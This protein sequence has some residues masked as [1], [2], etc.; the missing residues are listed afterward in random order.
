MHGE[1]LSF[2]FRI[3]EALVFLA[4]VLALLVFLHVVRGEFRCTDDFRRYREN[5]VEVVNVPN[6]S[7]PVQIPLLVAVSR[8]HCVALCGIDAV[9]DKHLACVPSASTSIPKD[10][11][12]VVVD[13]PSPPCSGR[14]SVVMLPDDNTRYKKENG[15]GRGV[16]YVNANGKLVMKHLD[17]AKIPNFCIGYFGDIGRFKLNICFPRM[18]T[19]DTTSSLVHYTI[20][21]VFVDMVLLPALLAVLPSWSSSRFALSGTH[22]QSVHR[23]EKGHIKSGPV[24]LENDFLAPVVEEMERIILADE[25]DSLAKFSG[26]F[27]LSHGHGL[28]AAVKTLSDF[29]VVFAPDFKMDMMLSSSSLFVDVSVEHSFDVESDLGSVSPATTL[30][31][32]EHCSS[33]IKHKSLLDTFFYDRNV[34]DRIHFPSYYRLDPFMHFSSLAGFDYHPRFSQKNKYGSGVLAMKAYPTFKHRF[35]HRNTYGSRHTKSNSAFDLWNADTKSDTF[36]S[37]IQDSSNTTDRCYGARLELTLNYHTAIQ[38]EDV[39]IPSLTNAFNIHASSHPTSD[40]CRLLEIRSSAV[41]EVALN[42]KMQGRDRYRKNQLS[43]VALMTVVSSC[44][45]SRGPESS[46]HHRLVEE[47]LQ[48]YMCSKCLV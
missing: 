47:Y 2:G 17:Y 44:L 45:L 34:G 35:Y 30:W 3:L 46:Q 13:T 33:K 23:N 42:L 15:F 5:C 18:F 32:T 6:S 28:K 8:W 36:F 9:N 40:L 11:I 48:R 10:H 1:P 24:Y 41:K 14:L 12:M 4:P 16:S 19:L 20:Q 26:F 22:Y 7:M 38:K 31:K 29:Q 37:F 39:F 27:F 25:C 43:L 21:K